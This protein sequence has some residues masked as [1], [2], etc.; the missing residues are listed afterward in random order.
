MDEH[1]VVPSTDVTQKHC[2]L[3]AVVLP[4]SG[5]EVQ[6]SGDSGQAPQLSAKHACSCW[7]QSATSVHEKPA[8]VQRQLPFWQVPP[9]QDAPL[10]FLHLCFL[11]R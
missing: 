8:P 3:S 6:G 2:G 7:Q 4:H 10:F 1:V 5:P 11:H 9:V